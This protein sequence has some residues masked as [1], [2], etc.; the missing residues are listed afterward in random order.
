M[1]A[2]ASPLYTAPLAE[3]S[4]PAIA[5]VPFTVGDQPRICPPSVAKRKRAAPLLPAWLTTKSVAAPLNTAPVGPPG[6]D[7]VKA[8]FAPAPL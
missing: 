3:E 1:L 8:C 2:I 4:T 5:V 6:T 7:T